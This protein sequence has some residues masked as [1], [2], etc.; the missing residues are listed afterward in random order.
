MNCQ[1]CARW[2]EKLLDVSLSPD[3][4]REIETSVAAHLEACPDCAREFAF[5]QNLRAALP[6]LAQTEAAPPIFLRANVRAALVEEARQKAAKRP[7][8]EAVLAPLWLRSL[9][10]GTAFVALGFLLLSRQI[11][12]PQDAALAPQSE[13]Q[14]AARTQT[15]RAA[16][17]PKTAQPP[18]EIL[19]ERRPAPPR[20]PIFTAPR[21]QLQAPLARDAVRVPPV[22]IP[23]T[24]LPETQI[25]ETPREKIAPGVSSPQTAN[26]AQKSPRERKPNAP[27]PPI[28]PRDSD[29]R[30]AAKT[31]NAP[32]STMMRPEN[33]RESA[34]ETELANGAA[35]ENSRPNIASDAV[36]SP[37]SPPAIAMAPAP[38]TPRDW[39]DGQITLARKTPDTRSLYLAPSNNNAPDNARNSAQAR[40]GGA[41]PQSEAFGAF[42][43]RERLAAQ[44]L[45]LQ[46]EFDLPNAT[47]KLDGKTV[48]SGDLSA[49]KPL[50]IEIAEPISEKSRF[51]LEQKTAGAES[52]QKTL[53][54]G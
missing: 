11:T 36:P 27:K 33:S 8:W 37:I 48:W 45:V 30:R 46:S 5:V 25:L 13:T 39:R 3:E 32:F 53:E 50:E 54:L 40:G 28:S 23:E 15:E 16:K 24:R 14:I 26:S 18:T 10:A 34:P 17:P 12:P 9:G 21:P 2:C 1:E 22:R 35:A 44:I 29:S 41:A 52:K 38:I 47:L 42:R 19:P 7:L 4:R 20:E 51:V 6:A 49:D 43:P 31:E